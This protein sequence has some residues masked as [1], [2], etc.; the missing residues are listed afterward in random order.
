MGAVAPSVALAM[1]KA[2]ADVQKKAFGNAVEAKT[3]VNPYADEIQP[4]APQPKQ[5]T[6]SQKQI[7]ASRRVRRA[8]RPLISP[9][10]LGANTSGGQSTLG[11]S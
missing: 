3:G 10:R 7:A 4:N 5:A 11:A 6:S 9:A 1:S 2:P 8:G